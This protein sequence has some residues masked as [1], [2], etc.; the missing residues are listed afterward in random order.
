MRVRLALDTLEQGLQVPREDLAFLL[1]LNEGV[2][3]AGDDRSGAYKTLLTYEGEIQE[4][5]GKPSIQK[6][7]ATCRI[8]TSW[9]L[10]FPEHRSGR[11][12]RQ[13]VDRRSANW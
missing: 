5:A 3:H 11:D 6:H 10:A 12:R 2:H 7:C 1:F 9:F 4:K 8:T 13:C